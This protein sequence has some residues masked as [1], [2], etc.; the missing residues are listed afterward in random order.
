MKT[1][2]NIFTVDLEDWFQG[3]TSTNPQVER[4]PTLESRVVLATRR[5][6]AILRVYHVQATFFVLGY[7]ADQHPTLIEQIVADG[8]EIGV[9]GY[10]HRFIG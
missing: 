1:T 2:T 8:H 5:L 3:L 4:W 9:H 10:Y 6:L 7:V